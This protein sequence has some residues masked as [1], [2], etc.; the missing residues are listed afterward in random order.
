MRHLVQ[1]MVQTNDTE[2]CILF[3]KTRHCA[4]IFYT[5]ETIL[6]TRGT[7]DFAAYTNGGHFK[8]TDLVNGHQI[9]FLHLN[10]GIRYNC[11]V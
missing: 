2:F 5:M 1:H 4:C 9:T 6:K 11:C 10:N 8:N 3:T 7:P